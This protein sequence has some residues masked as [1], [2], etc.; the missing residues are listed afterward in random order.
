MPT[1]ASPKNIILA[2]FKKTEKLQIFNLTNEISYKNLKKSHRVN[3]LD[4]AKLKTGDF[5]G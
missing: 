3:L 5:R 4:N 2:S 1:L